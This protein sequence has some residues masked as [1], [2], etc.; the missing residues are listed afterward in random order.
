M[1]YSRQKINDVKNFKRG[2]DEK[3]SSNKHKRKKTKNYV[4]QSRFIGS[5]D[6]L[7]KAKEHFKSLFF[8]FESYYTREW[9]NISKY[10]KL[11]D[12]EQALFKIKNDVHSIFPKQT[13]YQIHKL[14]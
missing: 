10:E 9:S 8:C 14:N 13:E 3:L 1:S 2:D 11:R 5:D 4:I 6:D 12:A 7:N